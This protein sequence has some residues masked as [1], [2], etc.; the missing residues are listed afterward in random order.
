MV[1]FKLKKEVNKVYL[2]PFSYVSFSLGTVSLFM[3]VIASIIAFMLLYTRSFDSLYILGATVLASILSEIVQYNSHNNILK[4]HSWRISIVQGF[5]LGFLIPSTYP[6][7]VVFIV[8]V[9]MFLMCKRCF[10]NFSDSWTNIVALTVVVLYFIYPSGF[11]LFDLTRVDVQSRNS[12]LLLIQNGQVPICSFDS[13]VT[14]FLNS[15]VFRLLGVSVPQGYV[16]LLWDSGSLIPAFRFNILILTASIVFFSLDMID[17]IIPLLFIVFYSLLIRFVSPVIVGGQAF[18]GDVILGLCTSGVLFCTIFLLQWYGTT[19]L[20][21]VGK[22]FYGIISAFTAFVIIGC[23][24]SSVGY[25]FVVLL[26][27]IISPV[28]QVI[29]NKFLKR[30]VRKVLLPVVKRLNDI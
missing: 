25:A 20:T 24:T 28:I 29:E 12:A 1:D 4:L 3:I 2:A 19:P 26:M 30:R 6:P 10:G 18:Q 23:G 22:I 21:L 14:D 17:F 11:N 13:A 15:T 7:V 8:S 27:N 16:S 9:L 5:I